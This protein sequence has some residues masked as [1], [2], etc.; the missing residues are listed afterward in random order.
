MNCIDKIV[1]FCR[2]L[3]IKNWLRK[4]LAKSRS[5]QLKARRTGDI[6]CRVEGWWLRRWARAQLKALRMEQLAKRVKERQACEKGSPS[7]GVRRNNTS[8]IK[9]QPFKP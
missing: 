7:F 6:I 4:A 9:R 3:K 5:L 2:I 1:G 8:T